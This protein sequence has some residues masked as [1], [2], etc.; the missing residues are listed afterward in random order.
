M[1]GVDVSDL[2]WVEIDFAEDLEFARS[3]I[4]PKIQPP[5][6]P[7]LSSSLTRLHRRAHGSGRG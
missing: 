5:K 1:H 4:L 7:G 3:E 6:G 2:P